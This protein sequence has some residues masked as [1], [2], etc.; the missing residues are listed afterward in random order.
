MFEIV[1][2]NIFK[3]IF[4]WKFFEGDVCFIFKEILIERLVE[5]K[6]DVD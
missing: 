6:Y 3:M 2:E 1:M 4:D 5:V